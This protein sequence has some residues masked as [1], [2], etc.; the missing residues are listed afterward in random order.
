MGLLD[1]FF[2]NADKM[3]KKGDSALESGK[4][5]DA[6]REFQ[7]AL[8]KSAQR[9]PL[10]KERLEAK[11]RRARQS[12]HR[13]KVEEAADLLQDDLLDEAGEA[14]QIAREHEGGAPPTEISRRTKLEG[15]LR[16][17]LEEQ[18]GPDI[19]LPN[20][21]GAD[22][23]VTGVRDVVPEEMLPPS[24]LDAAFDQLSSALAPEDREHAATLGRAFKQGF[25]AQQTGQPEVS[26]KA[27]KLAIQDHPGDG[28]VIEM[29]AVALD[30]SGDEQQAAKFYQEALDADPKR[31]NARI[32]LA[33]MRSGVETT[34]GL[35]AANRLLKAVHEFAGSRARETY[36]AAM[37][38]LEEGTRE[39]PPGAAQYLIAAAEISLLYLQPQAAL[40]QLEQVVK[41]GNDKVP[42]LWHLLG[43]S[44]EMA[45]DLDRAEESYDKAV[46]LGGNAM[47]FRA[48][49][50]EF[51]LRH[52]RALE[53]AEKTIFDTCIGC[54][55]AQ[56]SPEE[57]DYYGFL[58]SRIQ[59]AR[60][61]Y[62]DALEGVDRLLRKGTPPVM[63][64]VLN[65]LR[66]RIRAAQKADREAE[67]SEG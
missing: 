25:V 33:S 61:E 32:A 37:S 36:E 63:E 16:S 13:L 12:F 8:R 20:P 10:A 11:V 38:L 47:F 66:E 23:Q 51:A 45:G 52:E 40:A 41:M 42:S 62:K 48:E 65:E 4:P 49:F 43:L 57:L 7:R 50:A 56:V 30:Q 24:Q 1:S 17:R 6:M 34:H 3:E 21:D 18:G 35:Q 15:Q 59:Y 27:L 28:L 19:A 9:D 2:G 67:S 26:L 22:V 60:G 44:A 29:L 54:Q 39:D 55:A 31:R 58:L 64:P 53:T 5:L 46:R 14:L